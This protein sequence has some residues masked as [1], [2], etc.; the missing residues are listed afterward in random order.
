MADDLWE[1][2]P[3]RS[4]LRLAMRYYGFPMISMK[5]ADVSY[6]QKTIFPYAAMSSE[7]QSRADNE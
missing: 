2:Q 1:D 6:V 5:R 3:H 4:D 7:D